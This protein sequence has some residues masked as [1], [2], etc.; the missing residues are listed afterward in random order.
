MIVAKSGHT[1]HVM[2]APMKIRNYRFI[3]QII[4]LHGDWR[5]KKN[6]YESCLQSARKA[7]QTMNHIDETKEMAQNASIFI[8]RSTRVFI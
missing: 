3:K 7:C 1:A 5:R 4:F 6:V 8:K 2:I